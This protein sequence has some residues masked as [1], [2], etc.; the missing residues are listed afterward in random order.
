MSIRP[1]TDPTQQ[2]GVK[3]EL[4]DAGH[5]QVMYKA[6]AGQVWAL[7]KTAVGCGQ[8]RFPG[9]LQSNSSRHTGQML[10]DCEPTAGHVHNGPVSR[11]GEVARAC[12][13]P[14]A[15]LLKACAGQVQ[16]PCKAVTQHVQVSIGALATPGYGTG[17]AIHAA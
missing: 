1:P 6:R 15:P 11:S 7:L 2:V 9:C 14:T 17:R 12:S 13:C 3:V 4:S 8:D 5:A 10:R 16:G